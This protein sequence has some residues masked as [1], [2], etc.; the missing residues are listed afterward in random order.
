MSAKALA[1]AEKE[2]KDMYLQL[3]L[4]R[5]NSFAPM[6]YSADGITRTEDV[7]AHQCLALLLINKLKQEY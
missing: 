1:M 3:Y 6:V 2:K 5:R 7:A 4:E